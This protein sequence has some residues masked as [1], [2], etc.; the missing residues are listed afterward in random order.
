MLDKSK[1]ILIVGLGLIGGSYARALTDAGYRVT[2]I[3][4]DPDA[5]AYALSECMI[6]DGAT[7]ADPALVSSADLIV[8]ALYP[9]VFL[10]WIREN[11]HLLKPGVLLTDVTGVKGKIVEEVQSILRPDAE[12]IAAHPM[13]GR[14]V[15]GVEN[16]TPA[17]FRGANYIVVP[18]EKNT[19]A[20]IDTCRA[21]G[22]TLGFARVSELSPALH[23]E[24]VGFV[25]QLTHCIA[26]A[27]MTC[28]Q[29]EH[30]EEY[31]GDSFRDLTRIARINDEMWSELF[32]WN[33]DK[34]IEQ[35]DSFSSELGSIREM[36]INGDRDALRR[37]MRRATERRAKFDKK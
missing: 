30:L 16:S 2:A 11:Q 32:L 4:C 22:E 14:E 29:D 1:T 33:R 24:I 6:E 26:I 7:N 21:L 5:I 27:L 23:D 37:L 34:L 31:T 13:A 20:A 10:D 36:L 35:I 19:Q 9:H 18:T 25:S 17:I 8:F 28:N 12:F 15:S 3:D